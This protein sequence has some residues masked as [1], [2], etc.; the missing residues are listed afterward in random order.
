MS[1]ITIS[2]NIKWKPAYMIRDGIYTLHSFGGIWKTVIDS[3]AITPDDLRAMA[4][5]LEARRA[6][7]KDG[8]E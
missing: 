2:G 1:E 8:I 7:A 3:R 6:T 5:H 4:D